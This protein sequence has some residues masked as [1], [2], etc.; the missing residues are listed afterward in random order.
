MRKKKYI[1]EKRERKNKGQ[2]TTQ[3][4]KMLLYKRIKKESPALIW[5][6][7]EVTLGEKGKLQNRVDEILNF[8]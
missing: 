5:N 3:W 8:V 1:H 2:H 7:F 6:G 4:S